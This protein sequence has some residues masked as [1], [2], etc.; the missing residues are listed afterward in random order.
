MKTIKIIIVLL[1]CNV[2]LLLAQ[3]DSLSSKLNDSFI[4]PEEAATFNGK[5]LDSFY[6]YIQQKIQCPAALDEAILSGKIIVSFCVDTLGKVTDIK[7]I[8]SINSI[9]DNEVVRLINESNITNTWQPA[10]YWGKP[11]KQK[12]VM[13]ICIDFQ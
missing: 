1:I 4:D 3:Q 8:K 11:V 12:I 10:L 2:A 6:L 13:P 9:I 5:G 7:V